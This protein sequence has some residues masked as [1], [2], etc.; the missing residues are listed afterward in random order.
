MNSSKNLLPPSYDDH[1]RQ[2]SFTSAVSSTSNTATPAYLRVAS[3]Y[4]GVPVVAGHPLENLPSE[5][6]YT[7]F[8]NELTGRRNIKITEGWQT[9]PTAE[10]VSTSVSDGASGK[11]TKIKNFNKANASNP[12]EVARVVRRLTPSWA[13][14]KPVRHEQAARLVAKAMR[15]A[16]QMFAGTNPNQQACFDT[17]CA[18]LMEIVGSVPPNLREGQAI[19]VEDLQSVQDALVVLDQFKTEIERELNAS[20]GLP[21]GFAAGL[22]EIADGTSELSVPS[23]CPHPTGIAIP[24]VVYATDLNARINSIATKLHQFAARAQ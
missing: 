10:Y 22:R 1:L 9:R 19:S 16:P 18:S 14:F 23:T 21:A 4:V 17:M 3:H 12:L 8:V 6:A 24:F 13:V 15:D 11:L 7:A 20:G 2:N 5:A